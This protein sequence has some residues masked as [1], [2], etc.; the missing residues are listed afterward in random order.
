MTVRTV[1][2]ALGLMLVAFSSDAGERTPMSVAEVQAH[3]APE[4]LRW[5]KNY[6]GSGGLY[7]NCARRGALRAGVM[8][9]CNGT[10]WHRHCVVDA[11]T[12][13]KSCSV[14]NA[15]L[16]PGAVY[17][18]V[19]R[20]RLAFMVPSGNFPGEATYIRVD[21]HTA[22][23]FTDVMTGQAADRLLN[24]LD[25]ATAVRT[26]FTVWPEGY[27]SDALMPACN[28]HEKVVEAAKETGYRLGR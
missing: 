21:E 3:F 19:T 5:C 16:G 28:L 8:V 25:G 27:S 17:V 9:D 2:F 13:E 6:E 7:E 20:A 15:D 22:H 4:H 14:A 26:R 10:E 11:I 18:R 1:L 24:Q 12:D 23:R